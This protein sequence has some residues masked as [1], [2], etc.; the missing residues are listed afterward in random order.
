MGFSQNFG[1]IFKIFKIGSHFCIQ[2]QKLH[3]IAK[4]HQNPTELKICSVLLGTH[5]GWSYLKR[6]N[7]WG[8]IILGNN[9]GGSYYF[10]VNNEGGVDIS[11]SHF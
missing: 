2:L 8:V 6:L 3:K 5:T 11:G 7:N 9:D 4:F 1:E 10:P